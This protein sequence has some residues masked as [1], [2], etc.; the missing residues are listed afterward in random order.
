M[1]DENKTR[2]M[3]HSLI[4]KDRA[5]LTVTGVVDVD[6]FNEQTVIAY[7]DLGELT[8]TGSNLH[9]NKVNLDTGDLSLEGNISGLNYSENK[10]EKN[11]FSKL[12]K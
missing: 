1:P 9:I 7:T 6:S 5:A 2:K 12:F 3:P 11:F 8:I 10:K 4:L